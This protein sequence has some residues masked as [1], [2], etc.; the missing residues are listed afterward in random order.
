MSKSKGA[1]RHDN[2]FAISGG[3][4]NARTC[5]EHHM[6]AKGRLVL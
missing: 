3:A 6:D 5:V 4:T 2:Q 1:T